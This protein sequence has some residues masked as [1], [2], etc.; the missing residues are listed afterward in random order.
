M[1]KQA[2]FSS[3]YLQTKTIVLAM[4][5]DCELLS[6][7]DWVRQRRLPI[8]IRQSAKLYTTGQH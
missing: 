1:L 8:I 4:E 6:E 5:A 2:D 3:V 7:S